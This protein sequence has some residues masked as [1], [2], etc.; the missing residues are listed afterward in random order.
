MHS[1]S[2]LGAIARP[3]L[4]IALAMF[5][6]E[7]VIISY[8]GN[9][10][11]VDGIALYYIPVVIGLFFFGKWLREVGISKRLIRLIFVLTVIMVAFTEMD[12]ILIISTTILL[13]FMALGYFMTK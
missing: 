9:P 8:L 10:H 11:I 12:M 6:I 7:W 13:M 4:I 1:R 2:V 3:S 5:L